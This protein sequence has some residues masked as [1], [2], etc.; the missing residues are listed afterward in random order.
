MTSLRSDRVA[1]GDLW[2]QEKTDSK[3]NRGQDSGVPGCG[4]REFSHN[5]VKAKGFEAVCKGIHKS[6]LH[7]HPESCFLDNHS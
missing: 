1:F 6:R 5:E 2:P 7:V 4:R 3:A